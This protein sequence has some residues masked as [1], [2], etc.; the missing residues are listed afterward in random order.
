MI[1][2][3][4]VGTAEWA[5]AMAKKTIRNS[6]YLHLDGM[7]SASRIASDSRARHRVHLCVELP[8]SFLP[9][10]VLPGRWAQACFH[11]LCTFSKTLVFFR[12][13]LIWF[14][15]LHLECS[16]S[17]ALHDWLVLFWNTFC[18]SVC[19]FACLPGCL[20]FYFYSPLS[21][22]NRTFWQCSELNPSSPA[23]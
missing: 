5:P 19:L 13:S 4:V 16:L 7:I 20:S 2:N 18:L 11:V 3:D 17:T 14:C 21:L 10:T 12:F 1:N 23:C 9:F 6:A 8:M 22:K 15:S